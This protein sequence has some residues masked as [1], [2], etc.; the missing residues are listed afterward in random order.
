MSFN[1]H[2]LATLS[3]DEAGD[4]LKA[5]ILQYALL[6]I[7]GARF[8]DKSVPKKVKNFFNF[9]TTYFWDLRPRNPSSNTGAFRLERTDPQVKAL[10]DKIKAN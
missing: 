4:T 9:I 7:Y 10:W 3:R 6:Y 1:G 5:H 8:D 2:S